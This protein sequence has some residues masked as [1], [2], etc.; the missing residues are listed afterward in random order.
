MNEYCVC[1]FSVHLLLLL[2]KIEIK[3]C[4]ILRQSKGPNERTMAKKCVV[5]VEKFS[6]VVHSLKNISFRFTKI[7]SLSSCTFETWITSLS[8]R[9]FVKLNSIQYTLHKY[10]VCVYNHLWD[11]D[12]KHK[13]YTHER[14]RKWSIVCLPSYIK[15]T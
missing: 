5:V 15:N 9:G 8:Y 6:V 14:T 7:A 13:Y 3:N 10:Y 12:T 4:P 2:S 1:I 11:S